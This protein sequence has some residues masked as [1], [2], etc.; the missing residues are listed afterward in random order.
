MY[1][2]PV[3]TA[4]LYCA[5]RLD[6]VLHQVVGTFWRAARQLEPGSCACLW[7]LRSD[8]GGEHLK[9]RLHGPE[10]LAQPA[11]V[12]LQRAAATFFARL[13]G[14]LERRSPAEWT[15][16]GAIEGDGEALSDHPD[17]TLLWTRYRRSP[18]WLGDG[19][20][21]DEDGYISRI[22][23]CLAAACERVL[24]LE[25][26]ATGRIPYRVRQSTLLEGLVA[27]LAVS[28]FA[29][30]A[31]SAYL[32]YHRDTLL[33]SRVRAEADPAQDPLQLFDWRVEA[34]GPAA[35]TLRRTALSV[36]DS[37]EAEPKRADAP[38]CGALA[39][40]L[41]YIRPLCDDPDYA[42]DPWA[43]DPSFVPVFKA[44]HGFA[45]QLGLKPIEEA[46]VH[47]FLLAVTAP[48]PDP[49]ERERDTTAHIWK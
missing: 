45:N 37:I 38:W 17:R 28:G 48:S 35:G 40:L 34:F 42:I 21:L 13:G 49:V 1:P 5:G 10:S 22:T 46:F 20:F 9:V 2:D 39:N 30:D 29:A 7:T 23:R 41:W 3:L 4:N 16:E 27:G 19:P 47:H 33:R 8:E 43:G 25:T 15:G 24:L 26:D 14:P 18:V 36:W 12:L 11:S 31:R 44:F 32:A 6:E